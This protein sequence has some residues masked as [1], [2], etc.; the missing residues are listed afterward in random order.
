ME[1]VGQNIA[2][3]TYLCIELDNR[4]N[5]LERDFSPTLNLTSV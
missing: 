3:Q 4:R 2:L 5:H 1:S